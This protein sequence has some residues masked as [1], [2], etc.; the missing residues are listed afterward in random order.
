MRTTLTL[1]ASLGLLAAAEQ[2]KP[3]PSLNTAERTA[4]GYVV[5]ESKKLDDQQK[6]LRTQYEAIVS[7]ACKRAIGLPTCKINEDGTLAKITQ[8]EV[9][10]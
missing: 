9:K 6:Q 2:P 7:D 1:I 8:P 5:N 3:A 10:K 4:L